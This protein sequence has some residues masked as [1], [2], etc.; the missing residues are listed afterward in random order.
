MWRVEG[1]V[2]PKMSVGS[3]S[4]NF[5]ASEPNYQQEASNLIT[6]RRLLAH[7]DPMTV[8]WYL[9]IQVECLEWQPFPQSL[10]KW[11]I[12]MYF[13]TPLLVSKHWKFFEGKDSS[14]HTIANSCFQASGFFFPFRALP[15]SGHSVTRDQSRSVLFLLAACYDVR[16]SCK[17]T[18]Y[19]WVLYFNH[20]ILSASRC[21]HIFGYSLLH[22]HMHW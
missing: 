15:F 5:C 8:V 16:I 20:I 10:W 1:T 12:L 6:S 3:T 13:W 17:I 19:I 14:V 9:S 2:L 21:K 18:H 11:H 7:L 4:S 22:M